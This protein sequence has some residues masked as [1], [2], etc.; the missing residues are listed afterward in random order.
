MLVGNFRFKLHQY[1]T[2]FHSVLS[3]VP[4]KQSILRLLICN[5]VYNDITDFEVCGFMK[6]AKSQITSEGNIF[7]SNKKFHYLHL[8]NYVTV[9]INFLVEVTIK[10]KKVV[11]YLKCLP[12]IFFVQVLF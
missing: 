12:F 5:N 3:V 7:P 9:E 2:K 8:K 10:V 1:L 4:G 6:N 11:L